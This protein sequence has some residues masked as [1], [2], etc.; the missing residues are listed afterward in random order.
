MKGPHSGTR[1]YVTNSLKL[2]HGNVK[3]LWKKIQ[4]TI[5]TCDVAETLLLLNDTEELI[6]TFLLCTF[7]NFH[8][9]SVS[10]VSVP[11]PKPPEVMEGNEM[12][13]KTHLQ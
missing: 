8:R 5:Q 9:F 6:L 3:M 11:V 1:P 12:V 2:A 7:I 13:R 10:F 4:S